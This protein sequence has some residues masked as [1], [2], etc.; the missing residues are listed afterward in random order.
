MIVTR[1]VS[2]KLTLEL[3][4]LFEGCMEAFILS[5]PWLSDFFS[6]L[7]GEYCRIAI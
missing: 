2:T 4:Q 5:R 7:P 3:D 1:A 6:A